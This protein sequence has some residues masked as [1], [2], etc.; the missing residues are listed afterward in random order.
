MSA[1][2]GLTRIITATLRADSTSRGCEQMMQGGA[3]L[4]KLSDKEGSKQR[5]RGA[6]DS[7]FE[8]ILQDVNCD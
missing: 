4:K 6:A 8:V 7:I 5:V 3:R 2:A 1:Q